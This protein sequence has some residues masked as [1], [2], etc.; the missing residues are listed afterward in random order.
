MKFSFWMSI[1]PIRKVVMDGV[2]KL[3]W[4][5]LC[6][7]VC[8][9]VCVWCYSLFN[10]YLLSSYRYSNSK[11]GNIRAKFKNRP[12]KGRKLRLASPIFASEWSL[13]T[14]NLI[15]NTEKCRTTSISRCKENTM[16]WSFLSNWQDNPC[17]HSS[18]GCQECQS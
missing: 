7:C 10:K 11:G 2:Q 4:I 8:V 17:I 9:C 18:Q 1:W 6:V 5:I 12:E 16:I 3:I 14:K 15:R 13:G